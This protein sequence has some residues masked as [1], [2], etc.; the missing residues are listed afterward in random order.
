M[1]ARWHR[2]QAKALSFWPLTRLSQDK[3]SARTGE[4]WGKPKWRQSK[5]K[6][7]QFGTEPS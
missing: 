7:W 3:K 6:A 2:E 4:D 1:P 5:K